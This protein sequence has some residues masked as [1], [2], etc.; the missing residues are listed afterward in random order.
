MLMKYSVRLAAWARAHETC[1]VCSSAGLGGS[2][3]RRASAWATLPAA[4]AS[5]EASCAPSRGTA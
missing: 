4:I 5:A 3:N 1:L 2:S